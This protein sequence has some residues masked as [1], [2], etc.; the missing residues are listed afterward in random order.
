MTK[1][2]R[3]ISFFL[4]FCIPSILYAFSPLYDTW[5][6]YEAGYGPYSIYAADLDGDGDNDLASTRD[7]DDSI[8]V[9]MNNGDGTFAEKTNYASGNNLQ[10]VFA[11]DMIKSSEYSKRR[12]DLPGTLNGGNN[13]NTFDWNNFDDSLLITCPPNAQFKCDT[14]GNVIG[15]AVAHGG[16]DSNPTITSQDSVLPGRCPQESVIVRTW[17]A[18][19]TCGNLSV[20]E[21]LI[22]FY[23]STFPTIICPSDTAFKCDSI[24]DPGRALAIDNCDPDP[25]ITFTDSVTTGPCPQGSIITRTWRVSDHC[26]NMASCVQNIF[27]CSAKPGDVNGDSSI[28]LADVVAII[29]ILFKNGPKPTPECTADPNGDGKFRLTDI[30]LLVNYLFRFDR[31]GSHPKASSVCCL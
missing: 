25:I 14:P 11:S 5:I 3:L 6:R 10:S 1:I 2:I 31:G 7:G 30:I 9:L 27:I 20:C 28:T 18:S 13:K 17:S 15:I 22:V 21:Q 12:S 16:C 24:G 26:G 23:D 8:S 4:F 29:Y 19:D